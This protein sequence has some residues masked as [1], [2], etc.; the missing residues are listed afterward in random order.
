M[1]CCISSARPPTVPAVERV[2]LC[3][4]VA[5]VLT[6]VW[7]SLSLVRRVDAGELAPLC[8]R[9]T[10]AEQAQ[11]DDPQWYVDPDQK[12]ELAAY[13]LLEKATELTA[14][15]NEAAQERAA[16]RRSPW[17]RQ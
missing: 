12:A 2:C 9:C 11:D 17:M 1:L 15:L 5:G 16:R 3:C 4:R 14:K 7:V 10:A 8:M 13:G 6:T